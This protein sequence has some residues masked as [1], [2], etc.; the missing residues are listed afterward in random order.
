MST[1][2]SS[3]PAKR[4]RSAA[5]SVAGSEGGSSASSS[6]SGSGSGSGDALAAVAAASDDPLMRDGDAGGA[7]G[8]AAGADGEALPEVMIN[9]FK[10]ASVSDI[11][12]SNRENGIGAMPSYLRPNM[13]FAIVPRAPSMLSRIFEMISAVL[14][15]AGGRESSS[16]IGF[17]VVMLNGQPQVAIDLGDERFTFVISV[18]ILADIHVRPGWSGVDGKFPVLRVRCR[19]MVEKLG[20]AKDF[21][22]VILYQ[23]AGQEDQ[24]EIMIDT[25]E[26]VGN[27]QHETVKIQADEWESLELDN[28]THDFT[29][30]TTIK[31]LMQLC[32]SQRDGQ[33]H[34]SISI[35][36]N[37]SPAAA[38]EPPPRETA[39]FTSATSM[40]RGPQRHEP[41]S[42]TGPAGSVRQETVTRERQ[43]YILKLEVTN[44][45]GETSTVLR[46][47]ANDVERRLDLQTNVTTTTMHLI[48]ETPTS[49]L[50][51]IEKL[52]QFRQRYRQSFSTGY[53]DAFLG[54]FDP[55]KM[56]AIRLA[57]EKPMVL[58][59]LHGGLLVCQMVVSPVFE[60]PE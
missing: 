57:A 34:M 25:P 37:P 19:S 21:N 28:I 39:S 12:E 15:R 49:G 11:R 7:A 2:G 24:L 54:K 17:T 47:I 51:L 10:S 5:A 43:E 45:E 18:R 27:V 42:R 55:N 48:E 6:V 53:V 1:L 29:L 50:E 32:R 36:G 44:A 59:Y 23:R 9:I 8:A 26:R 33:G 41:A 58:S 52:D 31:T 56:V 22:R 38:P 16:S 4:A 46:P 30:Q 40:S 60:E 35:F 3:S 20:H 14:S 13:N